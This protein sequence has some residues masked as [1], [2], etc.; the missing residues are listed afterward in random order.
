M[1]AKFVTN[2]ETLETDFSKIL[3]KTL[4]G[5]LKFTFLSPQFVQS[6]RCNGQLVGWKDEILQRIGD[7]NISPVMWHGDNSDKVRT[8][9]SE[10]NRQR[11]DEIRQTL[12]TGM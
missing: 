1:I 11:R 9:A 5:I 8:A 10:M 2:K 3:A 4:L 6:I 7:F 12:C